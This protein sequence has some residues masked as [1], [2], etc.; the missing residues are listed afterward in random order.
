MLAQS[1]HYRQAGSSNL[2]L[3]PNFLTTHTLGFG[4][5]IKT[6]IGG[7]FA[8]DY[9]YLLNPPKFLIPQTTG[10]NGTFRLRQGQLHFRFTQA[11]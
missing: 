6:P 5:R 1:L 3:Q 4:L 11:F 2:S 7:S 8:I 9:G 10:E